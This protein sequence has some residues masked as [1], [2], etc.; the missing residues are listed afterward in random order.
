M[1]FRNFLRIF[2][3]YIGDKAISR[4]EHAIIEFDNIKNEY[5][6]VCVKE[7]HQ[8]LHL[9]QVTTEF[10]LNFTDCLMLYFRIKNIRMKL[11]KR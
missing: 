6:M 10:S 11:T 9:I 4:D 1:Y 5:T 2:T 8:L 7:P 3:L